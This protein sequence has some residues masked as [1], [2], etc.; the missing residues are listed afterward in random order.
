MCFSQEMS[1]G[2]AAINV[3][4]LGLS[5]KQKKWVN[6]VGIGLFGIAMELTQGYQY[7]LIDRGLGQCGAAVGSI[8]FTMLLVSMQPLL[9]LL[10]S[11]EEIGREA[12]WMSDDNKFIRMSMWG[13]YCLFAVAFLG[14]FAFKSGWCNG[15][16]TGLWCD[17]WTGVDRRDWG[18]VAWHFASQP[19][20]F[21]NELISKFLLVSFVSPVIVGYYIGARWYPTMLLIG[22]SIPAML[23]DMYTW[24]AVWCFI[25]GVYCVPVFDN[26]FQKIIKICMNLN[27]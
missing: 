25:S 21:A 23:F 3:V 4:A 26:L 13:F 8:G 5:M 10:A 7:G 14:A 12:K 15:P 6:S 17:T 22:A 2:L 11:E 9:F 19:S 1:Y 16:G 18:H 20:S 24:P 27:K